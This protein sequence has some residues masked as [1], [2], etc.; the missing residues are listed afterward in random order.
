MPLTQTNQL[1][2]NYAG[3]GLDGPS[4]AAGGVTPS[5][6]INGTTAVTVLDSRIS[7]NN[8]VVFSIRTLGGTQGALPRVVAG[9]VVPGVSFQVSGTASDTSVYNYAIL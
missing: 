1:T 2:N 5:V 3:N 6:T 7:A 4:N 9:S 8:V